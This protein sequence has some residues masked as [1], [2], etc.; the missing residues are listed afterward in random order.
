MWKQ[1][2]KFVFGRPKGNIKMDLREMGGMVSGCTRFRVFVL[3]V[4]NYQILLPPCYVNQLMCCL[5]AL[6]E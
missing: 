1:L 3:A 4:L 6:G 2:E 5:H